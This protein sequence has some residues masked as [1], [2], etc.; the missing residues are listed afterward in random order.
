[1]YPVSAVPPLA[2]GG[3]QVIVACLSPKAPAT[4]VGIAGS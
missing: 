4:A 3:L 1:M 2:G